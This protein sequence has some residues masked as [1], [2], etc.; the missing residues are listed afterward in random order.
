MFYN[1]ISVIDYVKNP[2][3]IEETS[4]VVFFPISSVKGKNTIWL[5]YNN[6][7]EYYTSNT[8]SDH[9]TIRFKNGLKMEIPVSFYSFNNQY[10]KAARLNSVVADRLYRKY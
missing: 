8:R 10:L 4:R 6:I 9:T 7:S 2:I 1:K 5:S 3:L